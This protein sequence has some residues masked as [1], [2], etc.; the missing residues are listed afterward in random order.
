MSLHDFLTGG[1]HAEAVAGTSPAEIEFHLTLMAHGG[2][3]EYV[4]SE[5]DYRPTMKGFDFLDMVRDPEIWQQTKEGATK[6]G[7]F[8]GDVLFALAKG[9]I[10]KK[11][12]RHT[13]VKIDL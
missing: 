6:V 13:G 7:A 8:T 9:F 4:H 5:T 10:K 11:V 12:E 2:L 1:V 3:L